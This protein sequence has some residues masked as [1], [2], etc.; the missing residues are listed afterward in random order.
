M[1]EFG[2]LGRGRKQNPLS[3]KKHNPDASQ[4]PT[5]VQLLQISDFRRVKI[6]LLGLDKSLGVWFW[7]AEAG[8]A[9]AE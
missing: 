4:G 8:E 2:K 6:I 3:R 5:V 9:K 7:V 1:G